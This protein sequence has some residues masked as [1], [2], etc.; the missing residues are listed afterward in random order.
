MIVCNLYHCDNKTHNDIVLIRVLI[1]YF[2]CHISNYQLVN[3][4]GYSVLYIKCLF[5]GFLNI[6]DIIVPC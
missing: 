1:Q 5:L 2:E 6:V 4:S 3:L